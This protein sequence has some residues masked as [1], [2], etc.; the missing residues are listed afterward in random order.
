MSKNL[1]EREYIIADGTISYLQKMVYNRQYTIDRKWKEVHLSCLQLVEEN[2]KYKEVI[3]TRKHFM[4]EYTKRR[5]Y[6][7]KI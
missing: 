7:G 1:C 2:K 6:K 5:G 3:Q 4:H